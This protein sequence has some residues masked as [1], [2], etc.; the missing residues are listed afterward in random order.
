[1]VCIVENLALRKVSPCAVGQVYGSLHQAPAITPRNPQ[2]R[3]EIEHIK[4]AGA[5]SF[6][7]TESWWRQKRI[8]SG[9]KYRRE[10]AP[11][12]GAA[13]SPIV[14]HPADFLYQRTAI[15]RH[16]KHKS[17]INILKAC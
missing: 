8:T 17:T 13:L 5:T 14:C 6:A 11:G 7:C 15:H 12:L 1:M 10:K 4:L 16:L 2:L 3:F 9:D